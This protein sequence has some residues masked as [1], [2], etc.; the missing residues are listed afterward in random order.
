MQNIRQILTGML[1]ALISIAVVLG[2]FTLATVEGR[3]ASSLPTET[4]EPLF[5]TKSAEMPTQVEVLPSPTRVLVTETPKLAASPSP[6]ATIAAA[7]DTVSPTATIISTAT[8][9]PTNTS[10]PSLTPGAATLTPLPSST[11]WPTVYVPCGAP[12]GW[13]EYYVVTGDTLFSIGLR[14]GVTVLELQRANCLGTSVTIQVGKL[15]KVPYVATA[16]PYL[17]P[18]PAATAISTIEAPTVTVPPATEAPSVTPEPPTAEP[19]TAE[20]PT[21]EPPTAEPP[22]PEP[23]AP[24]QTPFSGVG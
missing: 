12:F 17:S 5:V 7:T 6:T 3:K 23:P 16:V 10:L 18:T 14:Y 15:L 22:T 4:V 2:G 13:V 24:T 1:L 19:P 11:A 21:S 20:P 9:F 8:I